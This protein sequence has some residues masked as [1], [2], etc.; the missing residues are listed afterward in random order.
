[1]DKTNIQIFYIDLYGEKQIDDYTRKSKTI[2]GR[3]ILHLLLNFFFLIKCEFIT[4]WNGL[5]ILTFKLENC[6]AY[7]L[8]G[9]CRWNEINC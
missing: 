4:K 2:D 8:N 5:R 6:I 9:C 1:M 3:T 7:V